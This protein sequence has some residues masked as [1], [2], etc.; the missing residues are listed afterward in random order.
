[1]KKIKV[2]HF[3]HSLKA[4]GAEKQLCLLSDALNKEQF[5]VAVFC[6]DDEGCEIR[7]SR[8]TLIVSRCRN[9]LSPR[10]LIDAYRN[11]RKHNPDVIHAWLPP[12]ITTIAML[13]A[14]ILRKK[15]VFSYRRT[16]SFYRWYCY[17][18][19]LMAYLFAHKVVSNH[20]IVDSHT[21]FKFLYKIKH[22]QVIHNAVSVPSKRD[23]VQP[24]STETIKF[25]VAGRLM[26]E[27]NVLGLIDALALIRSDCHWRLDVYG[28]GDQRDA[29]LA[30]IS[31][32]GL[33]DKIQLHGFSLNVYEKM[34]EADALLFPSFREGMPNVLIEA[35]QIGIP[36][37]A[38]KISA[39]L[40]IVGNRDA[41]I[42][43]DPLDPRD[44]AEKITNFINRKYD[45][46]ALVVAGQEIASK[47]TVEYMS[48]Q[49]EDCYKRLVQ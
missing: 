23:K 28:K 30:A 14:G 2:M 12:S 24:I 20:P 25:V 46:N 32:Y 41:V 47:Y 6:I 44:M 22:G 29:I 39:T 27:K 26:Q 48:K 38:S 31:R 33:E 36:I 42:W 18:E 4:G 9:P 19:Y 17:P 35:M 16:M 5:D 1:M 7:D 10:F 8:V 34:F 13:L 45:V 21:P 3:I 40:S 11:I 49:Y 43:F 37:L 15:A